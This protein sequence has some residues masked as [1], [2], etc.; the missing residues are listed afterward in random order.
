MKT[1]TNRKALQV[2]L[3]LFLSAFVKSVT[4]ADS[5]RI[6]KSAKKASR[7]VAKAICKT[8]NESDGQLHVGEKP[9]VKKS[10]VAKRKRAVKK[11]GK[12]TAVKYLR[13]KRTHKIKKTVPVKVAKKNDNGTKTQTEIEKEN[14][15]SN[16]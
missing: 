13:K 10:S 15:I 1:K 4:N 16:Q 6:R 8:V 9:V 14:V 12:V 5:K 11:Q 7:M 3:N 2:K